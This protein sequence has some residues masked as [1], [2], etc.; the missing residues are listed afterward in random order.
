MIRLARARVCVWMLLAVCLLGA[1]SAWAADGDPIATGALKIQGNRLTIYSDAQTTDVDQTVSVGERAR[2]RTCF[3]GV[4]AACGAVFPGD[5]RIAGLLVRGELRGPE[6]P[7][8][9]VLETVPGGTFVLPGFQQEGQ[10]AER[11]CENDGIAR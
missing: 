9:V 7:Q 6:V 10:Q 3:G 8:P 2:V 5:P 11:Q 4:D 1:G